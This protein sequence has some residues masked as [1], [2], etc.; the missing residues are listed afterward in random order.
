MSSDP[1]K[2]AGVDIEAAS[3]IVEEMKALAQ[4]TDTINVWRGIGGFASCYRLP[5]EDY[6]E[7]IIVSSTDGVG[8][9][10]NLAT[11]F[12]KHRTIGIDLVAMCVND[13]VTAGA[14]PLYF[15]DY[16]STGQLQRHT[17]IELMEGIVYGCIQAGCSL[18]GGETAEMPQF[19][20]KGKYDVAGF[21]TGIVSYADAVD[22][23]D[24]K[25]GDV[26]IG[27]ASSGV[28]SNGF[29]LIN[30]IFS[31]SALKKLQSELL[32]PTKIYVNTIL[33]LIESFNSPVNNSIKGIAH[34]TGGGLFGNIPRILPDNCKAMLDTNNW[35]I[36]EIFLEIQQKTCISILEMCGI[37]NYGIGMVIIVP[38]REAEDVIAASIELG[39]DA[40]IIGKVVPVDKPLQCEIR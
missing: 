35:A 10:L 32:I 24:I 4:T 25:P 16:F 26:I 5:V 7:P 31:D 13:V 12:N 6:D 28:H 15:L 23:T 33:K 14:K 40:Y 20:P 8:T 36:P 39:E 19:Y 18:V 17:A 34:I 3:H 21:C 9:K 22:G 1:Y 11:K 29:S 37:F 38:E 27:L 2:E 30:S